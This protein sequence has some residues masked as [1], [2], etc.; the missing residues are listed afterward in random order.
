MRALVLLKTTSVH[1]EGILFD[2]DG[3][4]V[5]SNDLHAEAWVEAFAK[6]GQEFS[7]DVIR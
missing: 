2:I 7:F 6:Y 4:L 1:I 5:D 3:T